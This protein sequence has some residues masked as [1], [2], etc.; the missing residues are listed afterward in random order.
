MFHWLL[1]YVGLASASTATAAELLIDEAMRKAR[2]SHPALWAKPSEQI[3]VRQAKFEEFA[4]Y[5][6]PLLPPKGQGR[7]RRAVLEAAIA[8]LEMGLREASVGD[9]AVAK[10]IRAMAAALHGRLQVYEGA[11]LA[12]D[13]KLFQQIAR[14]HSVAEMAL[15][16]AWPVRVLASVP[17]KPLP[18]ALPKA[19]KAVKG[20]TITKKSQ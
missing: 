9:L 16:A 3:P 4:L 13:F 18:K 1:Q 7:A 19:A 5:L 20:S 11:V 15:K 2:A 6:A 17:T 12:Q 10:E 8:R 14:R